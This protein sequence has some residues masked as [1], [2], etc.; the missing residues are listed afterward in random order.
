MKTNYPQVP[1]S[2]GV[3]IVGRLETS[4]KF[5]DRRVG[6]I[7]GLESFGKLN[8]TSCFFFLSLKCRKKMIY[9]CSRM[10]S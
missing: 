5:N 6:I 4:Q 9:K 3:G 2:W 1:I 10:S 7:G 8:N